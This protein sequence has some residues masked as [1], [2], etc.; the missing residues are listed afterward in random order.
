MAL[1]NIIPAALGTMVAAFL[2]GTLLRAHATTAAVLVGCVGVVLLY[3]TM[4][5]MQLQQTRRQL[6]EALDAVGDRVRVLGPVRLH[7]PGRGRITVDYLVVGPGERAWPL[8]TEAVSQF[9]SP[10]RA[11]AVLGRRAAQAVA[12]ADAVQAALREG[13]LPPSV[14]LAARAKVQGIVVP[15]R[16]RVAAERRDGALIANME[17]LGPILLGQQKVGSGSAPTAP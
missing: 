7:P 5:R 17:D 14:R 10:A 12:A 8:L 2:A 6:E 15:L 9:R 4:T 1:M 3:A 13:G 11:Q 16:R